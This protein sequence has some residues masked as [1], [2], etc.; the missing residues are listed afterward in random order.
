MVQVMIVMLAGATDNDKAINGDD[1]GCSEL[2]L[3][4]NHDKERGASTVLS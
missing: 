1:G 4:Y 3:L 2:H